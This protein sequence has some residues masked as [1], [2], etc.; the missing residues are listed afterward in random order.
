MGFVRVDGGLVGRRP[1]KPRREIECMSQS[2]KEC[3]KVIGH[4]SL[5]D[6]F[7]CHLRLWLRLGG[8]VDTN[9]SRSFFV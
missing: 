8:V 1:P 9:L 3:S 6:A 4:Q 2:P 7:V 5:F